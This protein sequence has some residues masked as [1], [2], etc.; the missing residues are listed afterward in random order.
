MIKGILE[1]GELA[2]DSTVAFFA[3]TAADWLDQGTIKQ[4]SGKVS[5]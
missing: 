4:Q 5:S 2:A 1:P 3:T